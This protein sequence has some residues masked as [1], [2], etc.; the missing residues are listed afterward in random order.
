MKEDKYLKLISNRERIPYAIALAT[1]ELCISI[2]KPYCERIEIAGSIRRKRQEVK[3]I[4]IVCIPLAEAEKDLF[5]DTVMVPVNGFIKS[6]NNWEKIKGEPTGKY[7]Q[8]ILPNTIILDLFMTTKE[9]WGYIY[10][11]RTGSA[12]Y[13]HHVLGHNWSKMGYE[14]KGGL[15]KDGNKVEIFEEE[16]LFK[17][18][19]IPF[20]PPEEREYP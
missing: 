6:V 5:G 15:F 18:C 10:A 2:L 12:E 13:S 16:V 19:G 1:A 9:N 14:G 4:E 3:D 20:V 7:T 17:L 11:I 8:R